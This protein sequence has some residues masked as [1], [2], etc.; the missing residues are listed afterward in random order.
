VIS[1]E[2]TNKALERYCANA[3]KIMTGGQDGGGPS[4]GQGYVLFPSKSAQLQPVSVPN[5]PQNGLYF[6]G[7]VSYFDQFGK[8]PVHHTRFC[9]F[10]EVPLVADKPMFACPVGW[11]AH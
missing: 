3:E 4:G 1:A 9:Y 6:I 8:R 5:N 10:A 2:E 7:C 11:S